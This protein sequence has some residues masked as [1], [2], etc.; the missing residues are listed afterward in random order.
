VVF[1]VTSSVLLCVV[2]KGH[3][4]CDARTLQ[5]IMIMMSVM[6]ITII[7]IVI[8]VTNIIILNDKGAVSEAEIPYG[9]TTDGRIRNPKINPFLSQLNPVEAIIFNF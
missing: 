9:D 6:V 7:T 3:V 4:R 1:S 5:N 8:L 2:R